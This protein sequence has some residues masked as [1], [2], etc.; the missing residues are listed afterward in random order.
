MVN[1]SVSIKYITLS[2]PNIHNFFFQKNE[3]YTIV[4]T[5]SSNFYKDSIKLA[6][7]ISFLEFCN[8]LLFSIANKLGLL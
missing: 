6:L 8:N 5:G 7:L 2:L 3:T 4:L 1:L